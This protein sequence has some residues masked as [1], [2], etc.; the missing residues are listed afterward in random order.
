MSDVFVFSDLKISSHL[1]LFLVR[2]NEVNV[3]VMNYEKN[4]GYRGG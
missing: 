1:I 4:E 3:R 2:K